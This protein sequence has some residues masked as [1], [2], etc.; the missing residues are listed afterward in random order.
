ME[1]KT[2]AKVLFVV[3][4]AAILFAIY[5]F[6]VRPKLKASGMLLPTQYA[7]ARAEYERRMVAYL[8][9]TDAEGKA[10]YSAIKASNDGVEPTTD[11]LL[12]NIRL[13]AQGQT[14]V[15]T[16]TNPVDGTLLYT[17]PVKTIY[18]F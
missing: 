11:Q 14:Q 12:E 15:V 7:D 9:S 3:I 8:K 6:L 18:G 16:L 10:W 2:T 13:G 17:G 1:K 4:V 5:W